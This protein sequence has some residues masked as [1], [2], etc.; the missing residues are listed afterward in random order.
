MEV[1]E[2]TASIQPRGTARAMK[3][4]TIDSASGGSAVAAVVGDKVV[5]LSPALAKAGRSWRNLSEVFDDDGLAV[6]TGLASWANNQAASGAS[7]A[8][9]RFLVP[10]PRPW[11]VLAVAANY[12]A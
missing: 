11:R 3:L 12:K 4:A 1:M 6:V 9:T 2:H 7:V 8:S 10:V 5:D